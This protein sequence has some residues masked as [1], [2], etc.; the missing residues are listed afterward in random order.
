MDLA[1]IPIYLEVL[2]AVSENSYTIATTTTTNFFIEGIILSDAFH[3]VATLSSNF[4]PHCIIFLIQKNAQNPI[5][6][7]FFF[8]KLFF[9]SYEFDTGQNARFY[10]IT[11]SYNTYELAFTP[12]TH[13]LITIYIEAS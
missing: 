6:A 11:F 10:E 7:K 8:K 5:L 12:C 3:I 1:R 9:F 13:I 2:I 4:L